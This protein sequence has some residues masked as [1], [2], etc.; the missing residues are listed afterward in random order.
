VQAA[1][2][3][4]V[5]VDSSKAIRLSAFCTGGSSGGPVVNIKGEL[6]GL[7]F[8]VFQYEDECLS[9]P[10]AILRPYI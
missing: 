10:A 6:V 4:L 3:G 7:N 8:A 5:D 2:K 1:V 9:I